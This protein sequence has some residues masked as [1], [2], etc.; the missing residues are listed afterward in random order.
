MTR[1]DN[2]YSGG[3]IDLTS[4]VTGRWA[5]TSDH[6]LTGKGGTYTISITRNGEVNYNTSYNAFI[7][8]YVYIIGESANRNLN[9]NIGKGDILTTNRVIELAEDEYIKGVALYGQYCDCENLELEIQL[10]EGNQATEYSPYIDNPIKLTEQDKIWNDGGVWKLNNTEITD[11]YL[12]NQLQNINNI[13]VYE[14]LMYVDWIGKV[15]ATIDFQYPSTEK[16]KDYIIT[17][18]GKKIRTD[19]RNIGRR[20]KWTTK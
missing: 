13:D 20:E 5:S 15:K 14:N 10:E 7:C 1:T 3:A 18:D 12:L 6:K 8:V 16:L 17:E 2:T 11:D 4:G 19:W 9:L